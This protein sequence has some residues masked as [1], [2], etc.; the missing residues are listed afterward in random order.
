M[1]TSCI[2]YCTREAFLHVV[3]GLLVYD[4]EGSAHHVLWVVSYGLYLLCFCPTKTRLVI[5]ILDG[6]RYSEIRLSAYYID[7][8]V[9]YVINTMGRVLVTI[10]YFYISTWILQLEMPIFIIYI[11]LVG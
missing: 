1:L 7:T 6:E 5:E 8:N 4:I 3:L 9:N 11:Y 10:Y 2:V